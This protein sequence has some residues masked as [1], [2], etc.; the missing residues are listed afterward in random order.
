MEKIQAALA[1]ARQERG[2]APRPAP[3]Y[4]TPANMAQT[5]AVWEALSPYEP[6]AK[7]MQRRR[8]V[9]EH[10]GKEATYFDMMR[11]KVLQQMKA[12]NWKRLAITS[13]R[14]SCGKSTVSANLAFSLARQNE[15]QTVLAEMDMRRPSLSDILNIRS[16]A[17]FGD[18]L[19]GQA[20]FADQALCYNKNLA[21]SVTPNPV[22]NPAE[23]IQS[24]GAE[25][26][27]AAIEADYKPDIMIF[28]MPPMLG[29]DDVMAF[30]G[31][32]D[33]VLIVAAAESTTTKEIDLCE[34]E[35]ASQ[36]NVMGVILNKCRYMDKEYGYGAYGY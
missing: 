7:Q 25:R 22:R 29:S 8:I 12:N 27:I 23:L 1:K 33:C 30:V 26:Q 20:S 6:D 35:I 21:I 13:P 9:T 28:D 11:T 2:S 15:V 5:P 31:K 34:R 24:N 36:S 19:A 32:V 17:G 16:Q 10:G 14:P 4:V 3:R 18:V